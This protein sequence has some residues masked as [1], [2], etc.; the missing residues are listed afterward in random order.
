[1]RSTTSVV[2]ILE[3]FMGKALSERKMAKTISLKG[4][5]LEMLDDLANT[6][7]NGNQSAMIE[8][9]IEDRHKALKSKPEGSHD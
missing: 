7:K 2:A 3:D 8:S 9:L 5:T 6:L 4:S 1:M